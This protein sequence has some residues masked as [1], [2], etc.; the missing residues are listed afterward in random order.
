[1]EPSSRCPEPAALRALANGALEAE[2]APRVADHA[3]G[4]PTC[5]RVLAE[6]KDGVSTGALTPGETGGPLSNTPLPPALARGTSLGR[7][8]IVGAIG[9]GGMGVVYA[10]YDPELDRRVAVKLLQVRKETG[11]GL[12]PEGLRL[13]REAQ[14]LAQ[15]SHPNVVSV[16][17]VGTVGERLFMAMELVEGESLREWL[18]R[19]PADWRKV[20]PL[21]Q[22]FAAGVAAAHA[23]TL[24]HRDLKPE[25]LFVGKDG[26]PRVL[27]FGLARLSAHE[28][29][30]PE[31][32]AAP[33]EVELRSGSGS[34]ALHQELTRAGAV[35]GT[36][37][38]MAPEALRGAVLDARSDQFSF[39]V[40]LYEALYRHRPFP[41]V[42]FSDPHRWQL[43]EPPRGT[44]VPGWL[45]KVVLRGLSL[46]PAHRYESMDALAKA[47]AADPAVGRR[48]LWLGAG[49]AA[50]L[51]A[52][53]AVARAPAAPGM[54]QGAAAR[55]AGV[56]DGQVSAQLSAAFLATK[57]PL[58][59]DAFDHV[60]DG[61]DRYT[62]AWVKQH[63]EA[64]EA[65]RVRGEQSDEVLS[66]RMTCMEQ[67]L[68]EV[69]AL[70]EVL[71]ESTET[72]LTQAPRA[73]LSL[74]P[75]ERCASV[76]ALRAPVPPPASPEAL[77]KVE[78]LRARLP[79]VKA[80]LDS[81]RYAKG[82]ELAK[83][84]VEET[85]ATGYRP[86]Q[87]EALHLLGFLEEKQGELKE[88]EAAYK[89]SLLAALAGGHRAAAALA[90]ANLV[91][92]SMLL[93]QFDQVPE[94]GEY[95]RVSLEALGG[96]ALTEAYLEMALGSVQV[97]Q[98]DYA[99]AR[100]RFERALA[101]RTK[102]LG[103]EHPDVAA[104]L[105]NIGAA[106]DLAGDS[107]A[108]LP[109]FERA[110][111]I[112]TQALGADHPETLQA[113]GNLGSSR[114]HLGSAEQAKAENDRA[115]AGLRRTLGNEHPRM[116]S[117]L[118][119]ASMISDALGHHEQALAEAEE[120]LALTERR[121]GKEQPT[122]LLEYLSQL[123]SLQLAQR[124]PQDALKTSLR[125]LEVSAEDV[126][127]QV[128]AL[129]SH[130]RVLRA[131]HRE[132]EA[133]QVLSRAMAVGEA[134]AKDHPNSLS[135]ALTAF[136]SRELEA[137]RTASA[138]P[139]LRRAQAVAEQDTEQSVWVQVLIARAHL[140]EGKKDA[141][142]EVLDKAAVRLETHPVESF[143]GPG[144]LRLLL[145]QQLA[146][147]GGDKE[148]IRKLV[149][150]AVLDFRASTG[151]AAA[152]E[153]EAW[154]AAREAAWK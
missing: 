57:Q 51:G 102:A 59:Q 101:L 4:C 97:R 108:A 7:Y 98:G 120:A 66:L 128:Q 40:A 61:L 115:I 15:L 122:A 152:R 91:R 36:P 148:R 150:A 92:A 31:E 125:R 142:L 55:L 94:R 58:A 78:A 107:P 137:G 35:V 39:C 81:G 82:L 117:L 96:D 11:K 130:A 139:A 24:V 116:P 32:P 74:T 5:A 93:L 75:L 79:R 48:R 131:L 33:E 37:P 54:C 89:Q 34:G 106:V 1:M 68:R 10:A 105:N 84:L 111:R 134:Q 56:W 42:P 119:N 12:G 67:R 153:A 21:F 14:A 85:K 140:A 46:D 50:A 25:N 149:R 45:R 147:R 110:A 103:P 60:R 8:L 136:A 154:L 38:Y 41:N 126:A 73:V 146:E 141:A 95:A 19:V 88:A 143:G 20:L 113:V 121:F 52:A 99:G 90:A 22:G 86:L 145:A 18:A 144:A 9:K 26:R 23:R 16:Y 30:V 118:R 29:G 64:C 72:V 127:A 47:L 100:T 65:T 71:R 3:A 76:E 2:A 49:F 123:Q 124:R 13:L 109:Y 62:T 44:P 80:L 43:A 135:A 63:T 112:W 129:I 77:A 6:L 28:G 132:K 114:L 69:R 151:G 17:D 104:A 53:V 138:W 133:Q 27:D 83:P 70:T 87:A